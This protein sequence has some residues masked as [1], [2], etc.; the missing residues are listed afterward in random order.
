MM[1]KYRFRLQKGVKIMLWNS[2]DCKI[3]HFIF[4]TH[5]Q[6]SLYDV[7]IRRSILMKYHGNRACYFP[8]LK[9]NRQMLTK[10]SLLK[11]LKFQLLNAVSTA[12]V[13]F[14]VMK[15]VNFEKHWF[16]AFIIRFDT[17]FLRNRPKLSLVGLFGLGLLLL[18]EYCEKKKRKI[19]KFWNWIIS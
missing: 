15:L 19:S 10:M 6:A 18:L 9:K 16:C 14:L 17:K 3:C 13:R 5:H 11:S 12:I 7:Y 2:S 1:W 4:R 8:P